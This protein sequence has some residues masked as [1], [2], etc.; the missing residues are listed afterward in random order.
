MNVF[1]DKGD[2][3]IE[4]L[5][6]NKGKVFDVYPYVTLCALDI[7]SGTFKF[8]IKLTQHVYIYLFY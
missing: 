2:I 5:A 1:N 6:E 4:K 8:I 3:F 7:I